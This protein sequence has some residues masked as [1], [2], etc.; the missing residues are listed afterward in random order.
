MLIFNQHKIIPK[1]CFECYKVQIEVD[2]LI[3]L[4]KLFLVFNK[5]EIKNENTR[6]CMVE[7]R[8]QIKGYY[9]G[10]I[11]CSSLK[12]ALEISQHVNNKIKKNIRVGLISKVKRGC[13]EYPLEYPEYKEIRTTG[14]QPMNYNENWKKIEDIVDQ[15]NKEWGK[16]KKSIEGFNLND[17]L[18]MRNWIAYARK[19]GDPSAAKITNEKITGPREFDYMNREFNRQQTKSKTIS[20]D[21]DEAI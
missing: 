18:I 3:E 1:F 9:K 5:L 10:L 20:S 12:E 17:F 8:S 13:S 11:Y 7:A 4:I 6:K 14:S 2:S 15:G 16:S 19:V 21:Q